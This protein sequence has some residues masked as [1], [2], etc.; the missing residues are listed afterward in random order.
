[1]ADD[2]R[3]R[4]HRYYA[5]SI[6]QP[7]APRAVATHGHATPPWPWPWPFCSPS[8]IAHRYQYPGSSRC[9]CA[10]A[11]CWGA[12]ARRRHRLRLRLPPQETETDACAAMCHARLLGHWHSAVRVARAACTPVPPAPALP[13]VPRAA[14]AKAARSKVSAAGGW[15]LGAR[16]AVEGSRAPPQL[17]FGPGAR[18]LL[19]SAVRICTASAQHLHCISTASALHLLLGPEGYEARASGHASGAVGGR[20]GELGHVGRS[21]E[22]ERGARPHPRRASPGRPG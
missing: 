14:W 2:E 15:W 20:M 16:A 12:T 18:A 19:S 22:R 10:C 3:R 1:M 13:R 21:G 17:L 5:G 9:C 8:P 11:C 7:R 6:Y 4:A